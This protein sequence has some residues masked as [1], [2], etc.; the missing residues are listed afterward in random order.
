MNAEVK[1][2]RSNPIINRVALVLSLK[3]SRSINVDTAVA[4][5]K[6]ATC[7]DIKEAVPNKANM[8]TSNEE[9]VDILKTEGPA[10]GFLNNV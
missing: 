5:I 6:A 1:Y 9:P 3:E 8:D 4:P 7:D 2:P 10:I